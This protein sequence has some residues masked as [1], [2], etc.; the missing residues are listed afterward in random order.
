MNILENIGDIGMLEINDN[1]YDLGGVN[2][3]IVGAPVF[4][5]QQALAYYRISY[6]N[7]AFYSFLDLSFNDFSAEVPLIND[8]V[9]LEAQS[10][11][12]GG[13]SPGQLVR[14]TV[15]AQMRSLGYWFNTLQELQAYLNPLG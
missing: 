11:I 13:A 4:N 8:Y 9:M 2:D 14:S 10:W 7:G 5:G 1:I 12:S 6:G 15:Y 3:Y